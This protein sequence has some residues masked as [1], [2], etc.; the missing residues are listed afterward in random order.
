MPPGHG[1]REKWG[2][3]GNAAI[4]GLTPFLLLLPPLAPA[5]NVLPLPAPDAGT[6]SVQLQISHTHR[7]VR[8]CR[9]E[10]P[11]SDLRCVAQIVPGD[12]ETKLTLVPIPPAS[13]ERGADA[14][15]AI[16]V[17]LSPARP[18]SSAKVEVA[19]GSWEVAWPSYARQPRFDGKPGD[20]IELALE[21]STGRC[22][23][24]RGQCRLVTAAS[25]SMRVSR[26]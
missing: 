4:W 2:M 26:P 7:V 18:T 15:R 14:R 11:A 25:T 13:L 12:A 20:R 22:E 24:D 1:E 21:T 9:L 23:A 16:N 3:D 5:K 10:S 19:P 8:A 6:A 17:F